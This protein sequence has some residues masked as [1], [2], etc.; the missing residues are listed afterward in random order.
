MFASANEPPVDDATEMS[1]L[2]SCHQTFVNAVRSTGGKNAYR[3]LVIQAPTTSIDLGKRLMNSMPTDTVAGRQMAEVHFYAPS[4]FTLLTEDA[5]W[6]N[7]V[8]YWGAGFH[9]AT[10]TG[11]NAS[12]GEE[13]WSSS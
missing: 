9:L 1:L 2:M 10:D 5:S 11:R 12:W 3:V 6:G 8:Y 7:M 4:Q 13:A